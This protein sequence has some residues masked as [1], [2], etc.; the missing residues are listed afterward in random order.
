[1]TDIRSSFSSTDPTPDSDSLRLGA[2]LGVAA[3]LLERF[4]F[5]FDA[6]TVAVLLSLVG[7]VLVLKGAAQWRD[8]GWAFLATGL[9]MLVVL[10]LLFLF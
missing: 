4:L 1:M 2:G 7:V 8:A 6:T 10:P 3:S 5:A 9:T